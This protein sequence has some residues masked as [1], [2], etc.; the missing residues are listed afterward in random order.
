MS[1]T[2]AIA[3]YHPLMRSIA[4][5]IVDTLEDAE[6]IVQDTFEKWLKKDHSQIKNHKAYLLQSVS[7]NALQYLQSFKRQV[8]KNA[9][10]AEDH[11]LPEKV[12][13][14]SLSHLDVEEQIHHAWAVIHHK[15]EPLERAIFVMKEFFN[16]EYEELQLIF[17]KKKDHCRKLFSRA[18]AKISEETTSVN[19]LSHLPTMPESFK[20][21]CDFGHLSEIIQDLKHDL[22][23]KISKK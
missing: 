22:R 4:L 1:R 12:T 6:D 15:L 23:E 7:N 2:E 5:R 9:V 3:V 16:V 8:D 21:A 14:L 13:D 17:D 10:E 19:I 20:K 18:K 11:L